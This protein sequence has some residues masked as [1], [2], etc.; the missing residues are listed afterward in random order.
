[1]PV[2]KEIPAAVTGHVPVK[3]WTDQIE[4]SAE[5]Q[6]TALAACPFIFHHVAA[7]PDVHYGLGATIGSV[8]AA[9]GVLLPTAVGVDIGCFTGDTLIPLLDGSD[10]SLKDLTDQGSEFW[11][12]SITP[13]HRITAAKATAK[14]TRVDAPLVRVTLDNGEQITCTPDHRFMLRDGSW[15]EAASLSAGTSLMPFYTKVDQDGYVMICQPYSGRWQRAHWAVARTGA[16]G[17][18]PRFEGQ[19]VVIHHK[20]FNEVNNDPSNLEFLGDKDH[21]RLH[22][23]IVERNTYW[24]SP[25]FKERRN[26]V[27]RDRIQNDP[28]FRAKKV[29]VGTEN[30]VRYM[31]EHATEWKASVEG[32]GERGKAF[33]V[34]YNRSEKGRAKSK[35][36]GNRIYSC[37]HCGLTGRGGY[38]AAHLKRCE[39]KPKNHQVV[40]VEVLNERTDVYC[41]TVPEYGNFALSAGV[42]V[43]N[44]G[45]LAQPFNVRAVDLSQSFLREL[46][47][48][49]KKNIPTGFGGHAGPQEWEGFDD[50]T[51]YTEAVA[52]IVREKGPMQLGSLGGGNHFLELCQDDDGMVWLML[53]SGSRGAGN[54]IASH[55]IAIAEDLNRRLGIPSARDLWVLPLDREESQS[56]LKDMLWAQDY[57]MENRQR[58][59]WAFIQIFSNLLKK[60]LRIDLDFDPAH[61]INIHH[62]YANPETH[63]GRDVWVHRKGATFAGKDV[64][65]IIPGSMAT[66]S[67][68]VRGL[69]NPESFQS[70]S[71]GAGRVMS[72]GEAVR[73]IT[74]ESFAH[75]MQGIVAETGKEYLDEAPQAYKDL[76]TVIHNQADLIE[77][78]RRLHPIMN[79]K[80]AGKPHRDRSRDKS[81][82]VQ[83]RKQEQRKRR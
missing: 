5:Q 16:L 78:V 9:D 66:G 82:K 25:E 76:D 33:L 18:I 12:W 50:E 24:N 15:T 60:R 36:V 11:V 20:D 7:M 23:G 62:N 72:R 61:G 42:F 67:Y 59:R 65:G 81:D 43:H 30:I 71:H 27:V 55:H 51:R 17:K 22:R 19:R 69:G 6:L 47:E 39:H 31:Q 3:I 52:P 70:C 54:M 48:L 41:L 46:H 63:F 1:M 4:Q 79:V 13:S 44:C 37:P 68:I 49:T 10:R 28:E 83:Q 8:F 21:S 29:S 35:E 57:A 34:A 40:S 73:S 77:P 26:A 2:F 14:K 53:H 75:K 64:L 58:M 38:Y 45:M 32:N 74:L 80:G 56:Y